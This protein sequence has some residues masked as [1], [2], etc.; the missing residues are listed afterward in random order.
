MSSRAREIT[1]ILAL[2][3]IPGNVGSF[4]HNGAYARGT[5]AHAAQRTVNP[6]DAPWNAAGDATLT[7]GV[8]SGTDDTDALQACF[9]AASALGWCVRI[10]NQH[11]VQDRLDLPDSIAIEG[12]GWIVESDPTPAALNW[13]ISGAWL[14]FDHV[15]IGLYCRDD[16]A[17]TRSK[18]RTRI[19]G[20]GFSRP[21][22]TAPGPGW[23]PLAHA[24]DIRVEHNVLLEDVCFLNSS[25]WTLV[26]SAGVLRTWDVHGQPLKTAFDYERSADKNVHFAPHFWP[27]WTQHPDVLAYSISSALCFDVT[28][29]DG[30]RIY[31]PFSFGASRLLFHQD[32]PGAGSG[33]AG[34]EIHGGYADECGGLVEINTS[35]YPSYGSVHGALISADEDLRGTG[36]GMSFAGSVASSCDVFGLN[37]QRA[38][39]EAVRATG[40]AHVINVSAQRVDAWSRLAGTHYAFKA[41]NGAAITLLTTPTFPAGSPAERYTQGASGIVNLPNGRIRTSLTVATGVVTVAGRGIYVIDTEA[42]A[43]TDDLDTINGGSDGDVIILSSVNAA[44]DTTLKDGTGNLFLTADFALANN[45]QKIVLVNVGGTQWHELSRAAN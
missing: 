40:A 4:S 22:Q 2:T 33:L 25:N 30:L 28:R 39:E 19:R 14:H 45:T 15:V 16:A 42:A 23:T 6:M 27:M 3:G 32:V 18:K 11:R 36:A 21:G 37:V 31:D 12:E 8:I 35:N 29:C 7:G 43:A 5:L 38:N 20:V 41:D 26:R 9:D 34:W 17:I 10:T 13:P 44:R 24:E 1:R